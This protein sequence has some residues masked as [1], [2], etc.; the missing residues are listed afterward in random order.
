MKKAILA[1]SYGTT[2]ED[3][4]KSSVGALEDA[5]RLA[6]PDY[7]VFRAFTGKRIIELL[8]K[9]GI[10]VNNV[11][12][13]L[14]QLAR[15][16]YDEVIV[17]PTH[18]INGDEF[19]KIGAAVAAMSDRFRTVRIGAPL[20]DSAS[21][22]ETLC[23]FYA[24]RY[25]REGGALVLMGH[26]SGHEANRLYCDFGET[27]RKLGHTNMFIATLEATPCLE[28]VLPQLHA[29]G[30]RDVII[31]PLLFVAGGHAC[32]DMA[33]DEPHSWKSKLEAEG[34][35]VTAVV[36]GLGE[37]PEVRALYVKHLQNTMN[38]N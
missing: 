25:G 10:C 28:D 7:T 2:Y 16:G 8:K 23:N 12:E 32:R 1:V 20:L 34:F 21:D 13:M 15:E 9:K 22:L 18:I 24:E 5:F 27:C 33:G 38:Q 6:Y 29:G 36:K 37:Y 30:Y 31:A 19:D 14:T 3:A 17:Q 11:E 4:L 26:G 35:T